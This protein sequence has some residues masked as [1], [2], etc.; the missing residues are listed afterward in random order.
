MACQLKGEHAPSDKSDVG[1][2]GNLLLGFTSPHLV[3][4]F[5]AQLVGDLRL[6]QSVLDQ[7]LALLEKLTEGRQPRR[8]E[9][10]AVLV[11]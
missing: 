10:I 2:D 1:S 9:H 8:S 4:L 5:Q 7:S 3:L 6:G 11:R